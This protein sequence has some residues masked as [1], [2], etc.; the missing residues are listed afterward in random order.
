MTMAVATSEPTCYKEPVSDAPA[1][2]VLVV[3]DHEI[4]REGLAVT[5][6]SDRRLEIVGLA[7][8]AA[9]A[10]TLVRRTTPQIVILDFRLADTRG[11][12]L[13]RQILELV[14]STAVIVVSSYLTE[15]TV[16]A[17]LDAGAV[18]YVTKAAGLGELRAAIDRIVERRGTMTGVPAQIVMFYEALVHERMDGKQPTAQQLRVLNLAAEGKTYKEIAG[19]LYISESTVRFHMQKLKVKLG[20]RTKT[21]LITTAL[22]K[23]LVAPAADEADR[24]E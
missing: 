16:R 13:C 17:A 14:P 11:D 22:R 2:R 21:E 4:V 12:E 20:A 6:G 9:G 5:L 23:G 8:D 19:G 3:D 24:A 10:L 18:A 7:G 1:W 15:E